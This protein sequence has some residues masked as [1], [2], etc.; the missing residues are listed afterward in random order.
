MRLLGWL[1]SSTEQFYLPSALFQGNIKN[2]KGKS[3]YSLF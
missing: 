2:T 1:K 3:T